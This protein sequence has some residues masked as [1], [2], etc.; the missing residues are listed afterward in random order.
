[1]KLKYWL[2]LGIIALLIG[3]TDGK[4][5]QTSGVAVQPSTPPSASA[6]SASPDATQTGQAGEK[7]GMFVSGEQPTQGTVRLVTRNG[8]SLI[9]LGD[10]FTTSELGPDLVVILHRS[11]NVIGST[12]PPSYPIN[13]GDYVVLAPLQQFKGAQSYSIPATI[14]LTA[15]Q[16]VG[17]W[18]RKFNAM[19]GAAVLR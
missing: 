8:Q 19:F 2:S 10:D 13:A 17:I 16:S 3:C 15:Y 6:M 5:G 11:D 12:Q 4:A 14:D 9:E 1:M 18:C 7:T